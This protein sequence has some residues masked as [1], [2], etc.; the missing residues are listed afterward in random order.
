MGLPYTT[1][2]EAHLGGLAKVTEIE[3]YMCLSWWWSFVSR[4]VPS[5]FGFLVYKFKHKL[6]FVELSSLCLNLRINSKQGGT[7]APPFD[8]VKVPIF[9]TVGLS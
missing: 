2:A 4:L 3:P 9:S 1:L 6:E 5:F 7:K 8:A